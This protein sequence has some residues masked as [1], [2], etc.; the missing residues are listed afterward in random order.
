[1]RHIQWVQA[2]S[3]EWKHRYKAE[4]GSLRGRIQELE[5]QLYRLDNFSTWA[6]NPRTVALMKRCNEFEKRAAPR[7]SD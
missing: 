5:T 6:T 3:H 4:T 2:K 1:M 7:T